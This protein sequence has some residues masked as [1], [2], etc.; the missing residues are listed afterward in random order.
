MEIEENFGINYFNDLFDY[1][2]ITS[3]NLNENDYISIKLLEVSQFIRMIPFKKVVD[4][5]MMIFFYSLA[6]KL[7]KNIIEKYGS[8]LDN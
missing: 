8:G 2:L 5:K 7:F 1:F 3:P 6:S 4:E